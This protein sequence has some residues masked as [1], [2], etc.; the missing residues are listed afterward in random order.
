MGVM[1]LPEERDHAEFDE[2]FAIGNPK[3]GTLR[4]P[5][6]R[7]A[8]RSCSDIEERIRS[9]SDNR[10]DLA[11]AACQTRDGTVVPLVDDDVLDPVVPDPPDETLS[12]SEAFSPKVD[13]VS[14]PASTVSCEECRT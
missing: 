12:E 13:C 6:F 11:S 9:P 5:A 3:V 7:A 4:L 2:L 1:A 14:E 8:A 10:R